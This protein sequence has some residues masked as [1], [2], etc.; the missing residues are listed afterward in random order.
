VGDYGEEVAEME[1]SLLAVVVDCR[2]PRSQADFWSKALA[3]DVVERNR[4]EFLVNGPDGAA[5]PL[6]FMKV[7]EPK[8]GKNRLHLDLVTEGPLD[9]EIT[10][11]KELGAR[12]VEVRR[13]PDALQNPDTWAVMEDPEE[14]VFCVSSRTTITGWG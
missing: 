6:Y 7:P 2:D 14:H 4:D 3:H 8:V 9:D 11:L 13:D 5:S 12:L 10:R 1:S